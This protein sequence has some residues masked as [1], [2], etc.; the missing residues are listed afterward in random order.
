ML[1]AVAALVILAD[2]LLKWLVRAHMA[3]HQGIAVWPPY[4][5]IEYIQNPGGAFS[6]LPNFHFV[7]WLVAIVVAIVVIYVDRR[8]HPG[9][10]TRIG[11]AL[12]LGG[13]LGNLIDRVVLGWVTDYVYLAFINFPV[14]NLADASIDAG[15]IMLLIR[16]FKSD[17]GQ[18]KD[19]K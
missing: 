15:V 3:V 19:E 6:I 7:F 18:G 17:R 14:F 12:L 10:W 2:Q 1:Y 13:A 4:I 11:M 9:T 8:Y 16:S 5:Y